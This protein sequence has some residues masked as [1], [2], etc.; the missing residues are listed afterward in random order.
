MTADDTVDTVHH[1][2]DET[3]ATI[4]AARARRAGD[5]TL[6]GFA[7]VGL[8]GAVAIGVLTPRWWRAVSPQIGID[9]CVAM[10]VFGLWGIADRVRTERLAAGRA[11]PLPDWAM[12]VIAAVG[13]IV[14]IA[15]ALL[16][17]LRL[18][19]TWIS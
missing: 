10:A 14:S 9:A 13:F 1:A 18:M 2:R 12:S 16:V 5:G 4:L 15:G 19:G 3:I 11:P 8:V 17:F 7:I 6:V